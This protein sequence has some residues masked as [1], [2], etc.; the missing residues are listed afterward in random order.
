MRVVVIVVLRLLCCLL[1]PST[2]VLDCK[3]EVH[4]QTSFLP[5]FLRFLLSFFPAAAAFC[6]C[7]GDSFATQEFLF[8]FGGGRGLIFSFFW[9]FFVRATDG[10]PLFLNG[11][12]EETRYGVGSP[13]ESPFPSQN[14]L[15]NLGII[16]LHNSHMHILD[17]ESVTNI[18]VLYLNNALVECQHP[19]INYFFL[20]NLLFTFHTSIVV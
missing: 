17:L 12:V 16:S 1:L 5:S 15:P 3:I 8:V 9:R 6:S 14:R 7:V 13:L 2:R 20:S 18:L 19:P 4:R 10:V 11:F